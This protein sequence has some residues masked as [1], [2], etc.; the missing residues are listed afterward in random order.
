MRREVKLVQI[1]SVPDETFIEFVKLDL[2]KKA[3]A[4]V[5]DQLRAPQNLDRWLGELKEMLRSVQAQ[6]IQNKPIRPAGKVSDAEWREYREEE[7]EYREWCKRVAPFKRSVLARMEEV[8]RLVK[9]READGTPA[10]AAKMKDKLHLM[11]RAYRLLCDAEELIRDGGTDD[12][13]HAWLDRMVEFREDR[14]RL[15]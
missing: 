8:K 15:D 12:E 2:R 10:H 13:H 1:D 9:K 11:R 6:H 5:R 4:H 3:P 7:N 14:N